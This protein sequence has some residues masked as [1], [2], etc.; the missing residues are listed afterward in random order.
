MY[1]IGQNNCVY[2]SGIYNTCAFQ[3][4]NTMGNSCGRMSDHN[5]T[6]APRPATNHGNDYYLSFLLLTLDAHHCR[7]CT[8][9]DYVAMGSQDAQYSPNMT[10]HDKA[11]LE[12]LR[13]IIRVNPYVGRYNVGDLLDSGHDITAAA[14]RCEPG[15]LR[16]LN[17]DATIR[18]WFLGFDP[19]TYVMN[20]NSR[21]VDLAEMTYTPDGLHDEF[22]FA[23]CCVKARVSLSV[24]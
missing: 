21:L 24:F 20:H 16:V 7:A 23:L 15:M 18:A 8:L 6:V 3:T 2:F 17:E 1:S 5:D 13:Y 22:G 19:D 9:G 4:S 12:E 10:T 11:T 14:K